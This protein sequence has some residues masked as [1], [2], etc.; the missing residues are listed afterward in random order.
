[1]SSS[2]SAD[3]TGPRGVA[4]LGSTGSIG[5]QAIDVLARYPDGFRVVALA[6]GRNR[7]L[8]EEQARLLRPAAVALTPLEGVKAAGGVVSGVI[9]IGGISFAHFAQS[10]KQSQSLTT[11]APTTTTS[12]G[13]TG[14]APGNT[15][16]SA[17][18]HG[19]STQ[20]TATP[21]HSPTANPSPTRGAQPTPTAQPTQQ[22]T[23]QP[24]PKPTQPPPSH[25]G[26]V[27]GHTNMSNNSSLTFTN[28]ADGQGSLLIRLANGNQYEYGEW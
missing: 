9:G 12:K 10:L 21:A 5:R 20:K 4:V 11:S 2:P 25:T 17:P 24:T 13:T 26:T 3:G 8:L 19:T 27:I 6:A 15:P 22:P 28:P 23:Q 7:A 16:T 18:T 14:T 1:M